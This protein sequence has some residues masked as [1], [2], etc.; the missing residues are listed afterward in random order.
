MSSIIQVGPAHQFYI[1]L[2]KKTTMIVLEVK[3]TAIFEVFG[4]I[5]P[6]FV[7]TSRLVKN[8]APSDNFGGLYIGL[9]SF[10]EVFYGFYQQNRLIQDYLG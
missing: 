5:F 8:G 7:N 1:Q 9:S 10:N 2:A 6:L 3:G 4:N